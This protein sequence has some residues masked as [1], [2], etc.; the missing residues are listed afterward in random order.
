MAESLH[1]RSKRAPGSAGELRSI[2]VDPPGPI[3]TDENA[4]AFFETMMS[5][6]TEVR[7]A[8]R[9]IWEEIER[10]AN[11]GDVETIRA[12]AVLSRTASPC[13]VAEVHLKGSDKAS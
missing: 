6:A 1:P 9:R 5:I 2:K 12:I 7:V 4:P 3:L 11:A 13:E 8:E 10:L